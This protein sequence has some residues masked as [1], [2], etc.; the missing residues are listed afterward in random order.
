[1]SRNPPTGGVYLTIYISGPLLGHLEEEATKEDMKVPG[2]IR[3]RLL[4]MAPPHI[5]ILARAASVPRSNAPT[6][7][8]KPKPEPPPPPKPSFD[9]MVEANRQKVLDLDAK[10]YTP[11]A[12]GAVLRLP[13]RVVS[14]ILYTKAK[15][16]KGAPK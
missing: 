6:T 12:I 2:W 4:D 15:P 14:E 7:V 1:M 10:A 3:E 8:S 9:Q 16:K 5:Q 13:Y 11:N